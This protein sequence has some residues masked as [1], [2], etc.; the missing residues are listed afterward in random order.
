MT[1][2]LA[3]EGTVKKLSGDGWVGQMQRSAKKKQTTSKVQTF[4]M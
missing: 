2:E 4:N 1:G 3:R